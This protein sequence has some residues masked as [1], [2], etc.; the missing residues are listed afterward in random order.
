[1]EKKEYTA[2]KMDIV[3]FKHDNYL[4]CASGCQEE[5][6]DGYDDEFSLNFG[7]SKKRN[8]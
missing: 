5:E 3:M 8:A 6:V 1:M 4:L 2:P 7:G